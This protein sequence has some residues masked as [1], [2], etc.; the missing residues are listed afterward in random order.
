MA[1]KSRTVGGQN[2]PLDQIQD[3]NDEFVDDDFTSIYNGE[4][5]PIR[6]YID[7]VEERRCNNL[8]IVIISMMAFVCIILAEG[9]GH[10]LEGTKRAWNA[11]RDRLQNPPSPSPDPIY[12]GNLR[13]YGSDWDIPGEYQ[14]GS[15]AGESQESQETA[16][17]GIAELAYNE[18][19]S[20][21]ENN[22]DSYGHDIEGEQNED[23]Q[24]TIVFANDDEERLKLDPSSKDIN[25]VNLKPNET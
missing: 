21:H 4:I 6:N 2:V 23:H 3:F 18:S 22:L 15:S 17:S 10:Y 9:R 1:E 7:P 5:M 25:D 19:D 24:S 16:N 12:H 13:P 14:S 11:Q 20:V 8:M